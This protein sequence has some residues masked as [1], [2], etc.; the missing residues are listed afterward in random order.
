MIGRTLERATKNTIKNRKPDVDDADALPSPWLE[1]ADYF[2]RGGTL[3]SN[4]C[5]P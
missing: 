4:N 1:S 5:R 3:R 2:D